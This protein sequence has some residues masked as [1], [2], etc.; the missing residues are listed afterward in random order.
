MLM[1]HSRFRLN[2]ADVTAQVLDGE[3]IMINLSTG[4]YYSMDKVGGFLWTIITGGHS[5][6]EAAAAVGA[7]YEVPAERAQAD[8]TRVAEELISECLI[9]VADDVP[10]P[11]VTEERHS[12]SKL[13]YESPQLNIYRDM[14][15]LLALDPPIPAFNEIAWK[16][17]TDRSTG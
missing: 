13:V 10:P 7:R 5:L 2:D 3:A 12:Q 1:P 4:V 17:S 15:E 9:I 14:S 6:A 16:E 8:V 11:Q